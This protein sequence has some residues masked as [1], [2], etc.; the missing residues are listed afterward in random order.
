MADNHECANQI[1]ESSDENDN[2]PEHD[3]N[4]GEQI[5][6]F[7][8]LNPTPENQKAQKLKETLAD[9]RFTSKKTSYRT[10]IMC[11]ALE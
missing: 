3:P 10:I 11:T 7:M 4:N 8:S 6:R 1:G 5:L 2:D 9:Y